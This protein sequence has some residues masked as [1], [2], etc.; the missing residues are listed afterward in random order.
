MWFLHTQ[1][2]DSTAIPF[3]YFPAANKIAVLSN[4]ES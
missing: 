3:K 2:A 4:L 1:K